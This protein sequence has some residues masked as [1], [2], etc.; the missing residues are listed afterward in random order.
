M[1]EAPAPERRGHHQGGEA[2]RG[3]ENFA[4]AGSQDG[5]HERCTCVRPTFEARNLTAFRLR[6][7]LAWPW[8]SC[9]RGYLL[10][11]QGD[12]LRM[13]CELEVSLQN[14]LEYCPSVPLL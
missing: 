2:H 9:F 6:F 12:F 13:L 11:W 14:N 5:R 1:G 3:P 7:Q 4:E 8:C 10:H